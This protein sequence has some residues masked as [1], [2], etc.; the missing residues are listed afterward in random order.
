MVG[1]TSF[2][3]LGEDIEPLY[4]DDDF[5]KSEVIEPVTLLQIVRT[6]RIS[7]R[8]FRFISKRR[9]SATRSLSEG[10][11]LFLTKNLLKLNYYNIIFYFSPVM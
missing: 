1:S 5:L 8:P 4:A 10:E 7:M 3:L 11:K 6:S 2:F 9:T